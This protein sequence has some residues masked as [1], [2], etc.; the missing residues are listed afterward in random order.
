MKKQ[1]GKHL[2]FDA[3]GV[4][5]NKLNKIEI[6]FNF[7]DSLPEK[8]GMRKL[9]TPYVVVAKP[10]KKEEWGISGF[11]M[12]YESHISCHTWPEKNYVSLDV[13]SCKDFD[14]KN[15]LKFLKEFWQP[16]KFKV[17]IIKRG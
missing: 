15:V 4:S 12:I 5:K 7:L 13:Y 16:Q 9:T 10:D 3:Y 1:F 6:V 14:E 2:T 8:I 17:N 11:V